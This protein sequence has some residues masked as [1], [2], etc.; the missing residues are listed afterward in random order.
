LEAQMQ[1]EYEEEERIARQ[2]KEEDNLISWDN[3]Q[4]MM[5]A[6]YELAQRLQAE[7]HIELTI[8]ERPELFVELMDKRKKHFVKLRAEE[9]RRKPLTKAH[10]RNQ[11]YSFVPKDSEVVKG[12]KSQA[13]VSKKR[14]RKEIDEESI[15]RQK[16]EDDAEKAELKA[17]LEIVL[18]DDSSVNIIRADGS[19]KFYKIFSAML[20]DFD[21][22]DVLDL[23]RLVKERFETT[24]PEGYDRLL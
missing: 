7:E 19:T 1:A 6:D 13:E 23:Y 9:I 12:S 22:Q 20:D 8:E 10:K 5:E 15:K 11:M 16:L 17:C 21:R 24:S 3:T 18:D 4:A 2:R 14:T